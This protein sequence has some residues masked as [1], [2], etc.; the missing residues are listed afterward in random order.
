M[1]F[2]QQILKQS[3]KIP[4]SKVRYVSLK[5]QIKKRNK[6]FQAFLLKF[7]N[8]ENSYTPIEESIHISPK[9]LVDSKK[10]SLPKL[11]VTTAE[12]IKIR[13]LQQF[14][15]H[16]NVVANN[17][18]YS[19]LSRINEENRSLKNQ[20]MVNSGNNSAFSSGGADTLEQSH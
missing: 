8:P 19:N 9:Q 15:E 6:S 2:G 18:I 1:I 14:S 13:Q 16:H 12:Y 5:D 3:N 20:T 17:S 10:D 4:P 7:N 11:P